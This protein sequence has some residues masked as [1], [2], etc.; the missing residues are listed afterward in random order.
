[1]ISLVVKGGSRFFKKCW[2]KS[3]NNKVAIQSVMIISIL[4]VLNA[5]GNKYVLRTLHIVIFL[6]LHI[7]VAKYTGIEACNHTQLQCGNAMLKGV[8]ALASSQ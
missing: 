2:I 3:F 1:M 8:I 6:E 4:C 5:L 7:N